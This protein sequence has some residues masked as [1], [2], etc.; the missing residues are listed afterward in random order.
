MKNPILSLLKEIGI[1]SILKQSIFTK[2]EVGVLHYLA[3]LHF[4]YMIV[5]QKRQSAFIKQ[6]DDVFG[7]DLLSNF[8]PRRV[9]IGAKCC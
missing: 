9:L 4:L 6:S 7:K 5:L 1:A 8:F 3:L 2:C